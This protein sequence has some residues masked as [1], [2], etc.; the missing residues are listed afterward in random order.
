MEVCILDG[1]KIERHGLTTDERG[2]KI[3]ALLLRQTDVV[4]YEAR[5]YG[6][7]LARTLQNAVGCALVPLNAGDL[8]IIWQSRKKTDK[9]DALKLAKY[10]RDTP[11]EERCVVPLPREAEEQFRSAISLKEYLKKER[12]AAINRLHALYGQMGL[13]DVTK[14]DLKDGKG[15]HARHG[16]LPAVLQEYATVLESQLELFEQQLAVME[17]KVAEQA[18]NHELIA[19]IMS[20]PGIGLGIAA[21]ILAYIGDGSRFSKACQVA[22]YAGLA[23]RVDC[24]GETERYG[25]IARYQFC[26]PIRAVVL[27]GVWALVKSGKG[28]LFDKYTELSGRMSKRKS[29]VVVARKMVRLAWLLISG[30]S[31]TRE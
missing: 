20:I 19:Y 17:E 4:G 15:R 18:R 5:G 11:E 2:Q 13:I 12:T 25:S 10:L 6:N 7:R 14:K 16:E 30:G 31:I 27:E 28:P 29:A 22:N 1:D 23:P 9:E 21:V 24:S 26:H 3:L 8:R